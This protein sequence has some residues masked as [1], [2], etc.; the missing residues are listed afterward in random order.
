[1]KWY[2]RVLLSITRR[3]MKSFLLF[4]I[5]FLLGCFVTVGVAFSTA[6]NNINHIIQMQLGAKLSIQ[7]HLFESNEYYSHYLQD[8]D[9]L[10]HTMEQLSKDENVLYS[11][12]NLVFYMRN[13]CLERNSSDHTNLDKYPLDPSETRFYNTSYLFGVNDAD[14]YAD[15]AEKNIQITEGRTF[16]ED[17]MNNGE[18][19]IIIDDDYVNLIY[20]KNGFEKIEVG[21]KIPLL[22]PVYE[23]ESRENIAYTE[24]IEF[25]V[26]GKFK[27]TRSF[28]YKNG[29]GSLDCVNL[30]F[31]TPNET[32]KK[33]I[34]RYN[35]LCME[36][37]FTFDKLHSDDNPVT[38]P[39]YFYRPLFKLSSVDQLETFTQTAESLLEPLSENYSII[40]S[41]TEFNNISQ[42]IS[43]FKV[44]IKIVL[45]GIVLASCIILFLII[46]LF[47]KDRE[48]EVGIYMSQGERK[49]NILF[50]FISEILII[51]I[52]AMFC[53]IAIGSYVATNTS[54]KLIERQKEIIIEQ[55]KDL[56]KGYYQPVTSDVDNL[57]ILL[58]RTTV[59]LSFDTVMIIILITFVI[60]LLSATLPLIHVLKTD[61]RK[62]LIS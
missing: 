36:H 2:K 11:G 39:Y 12:Y 22:L 30:R 35:H 32:V 46:Y 18:P 52:L 37:G 42:S 10:Y 16:T 27:A 34:D 9:A 58:N 17:E 33:M 53:S 28:M 38:M 49:N 48:K 20:T 5:V 8:F 23:N 24:T 44:S 41:T 57:I 1:M 51:S 3:K 13:N 25:T 29:C 62:V 43:F 59:G 54:S 47:M 7:G 19:S 26:I 56:H 61:V 21:D 55:E 6:E 14:L 40:S 50:Q 31:Y 45:I 4:L 60:L 15:L